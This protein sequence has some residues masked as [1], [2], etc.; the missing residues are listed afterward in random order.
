[1]RVG[2]V[3]DECQSYAEGCSSKH[4][5]SRIVRD[6]FKRVAIDLGSTMRSTEAGHIDFK[7]RAWLNRAIAEMTAAIEVGDHYAR[8]KRCR[9]LVASVPGSGHQVG[10]SLRF[11]NRKI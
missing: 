10:C 6:G 2:Q 1:M 3:S 7:L 11:A 5:S 8:V 9:A 4:L